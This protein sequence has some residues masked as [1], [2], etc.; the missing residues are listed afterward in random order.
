MVLKARNAKNIR[1]RKSVA[2]A[3]PLSLAMDSSI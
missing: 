3:E 2:A 1:A